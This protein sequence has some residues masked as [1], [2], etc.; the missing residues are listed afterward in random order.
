MRK[1]SVPKWNDE[2][3]IVRNIPRNAKLIV[4]LYDKYDGK[5]ADDYIARF[6]IPDLINYNPPLKG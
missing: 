3:W 2:E 6:I 5:L 1:T 4:K